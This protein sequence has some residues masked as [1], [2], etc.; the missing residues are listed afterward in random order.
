MYAMHYTRPDIA[1]AISLL[2]RFTSNP[3][4]KY[5]KTISRILAYLK[6]LSYK[7]YPGAL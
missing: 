3:G 4:T 1:H 5:W 7:W 6:S 2:C